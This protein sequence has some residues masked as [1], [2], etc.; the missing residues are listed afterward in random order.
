MTDIRRYV[1]NIICIILY[2]KDY[3]GKW[4]SGD[5]RQKWE[6]AFSV[7]LIDPIIT[8]I[9]TKLRNAYA[10]AMKGTYLDVCDMYIDTGHTCLSS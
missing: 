10:F 3:I 4:S 9:E 8:N 1:N 2:L 6:K 5:E 7:I